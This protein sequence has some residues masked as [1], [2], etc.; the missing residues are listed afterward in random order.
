MY[1]FKYL[2]IYDI[3][4]YVTYANKFTNFAMLQSS[5]CPLML[6]PKIDISNFFAHKKKQPNGAFGGGD[7]IF[8]GWRKFLPKKRFA[9]SVLMVLC[10]LTLI[11]TGLKEGLLGLRSHLQLG[12]AHY[13]TI[14]SI[15][16]NNGMCQGLNSLSWEWSSHLS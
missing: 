8:T 2:Y 10:F 11:P 9:C 14:N 3:Y 6:S 15:K 16:H 1:I 4:I 13:K 7:I 12:E 5:F